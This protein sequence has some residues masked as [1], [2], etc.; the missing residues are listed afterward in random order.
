MKEEEKT[1]VVKKACP[2]KGKAI[3]FF[4][5]V[6]TGTIVTIIAFVACSLLQG[7]AMMPQGNPQQ[8]QQMQ[9]Q[10]QGGPQMQMRGGQPGR[11]DREDRPSHDKDDADTK[12]ESTED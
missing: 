7:R 4:V 12:K 1:L 3:S 8:M 9:Q 2:E 6:L 10:M 5:G 11:G